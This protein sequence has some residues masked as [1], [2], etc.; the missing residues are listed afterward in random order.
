MH[1]GRGT[2]SNPL[3]ILT[4]GHSYCVALNR[5]FIRELARDPDFDV[6]MAAPSFFHGDLRPITIEPEPAGSQLHMVPLETRR[7]RFIHVFGYDDPALKKLIRDG[8]FDVI[9]VWEEPYIYAGYQIARAASDSTAKFCFWTAQNIVKRYPPPFSYFE[10]AVLAR[11]QGWIAQASLVY[12]AML[13]RGYP[14]DK[15]ETVTLAVDTSAFQPQT[16]ASRAEVLRELGLR[17][18]VV[19]FVGR[20]TQAKGI[21][22]LMQAMEGLPSSQCWSMLLLGS[23]EYKEKIQAW[24]S[25]RGWSDRVRIVLAKHSE[26]PRYIGCMDFLVAP[27]QTMKNWKEQFGRM[28]VEAFASG[29]PLIG[30]DSG[31]I[32]YVVGDGGKIVPEK[33]VAAWS[34]AIEHLLTRPAVLDE[35]RQRSLERAQ[36]FSVV[37]I[38]EKYREYFRWLAGQPRLAPILV[39]R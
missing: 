29:V 1:E 14:K 27:S 28:I 13:E 12:E 17:A 25:R 39:E 20:L 18:P 33:D 34:Q 30:S 24:A 37:A 22:I 2:M 5:A 36:L 23:G 3:R 7:S 26:V 15:G 11:A 10:K 38:A 32:P 31:E 6:T 35:L 8:N 9:H 4:I 19:G 16:S 21:D